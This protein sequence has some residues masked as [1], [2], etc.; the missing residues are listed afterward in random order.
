ML[1]PCPS[2][3]AQFVIRM[4]EETE[5]LLPTA[6]LSSP[7]LMMQSRIMALVSAR[8]MASVLCE[9]FGSRWRTGHKL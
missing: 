4:S 3:K 1:Q 2:P 7:V 6:T 9:G 5:A 8:S